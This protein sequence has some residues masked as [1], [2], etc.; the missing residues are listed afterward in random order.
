MRSNARPHRRRPGG[1]SDSAANDVSYTVD[2]LGEDLTMTDQNGSTHAY[3]ITLG[4]ETADAVTTL[5]S[6]VDGAVRRLTYSFNDAGLPYQQTSYSAASGGSVVNQEEDI[7]NGLWQLITQYQAASG[8]VSGGTPAV[9]YN[10][11]VMSDGQNNSKLESTVYPNG[12]ILDT[13]YSPNQEP[14]TGIAVSGTTATV[15]TAVAHGLSTGA[16]VTIA[17]AS[18]PALDGTFTITVTNSTHF[19]Y[20]FTGSASTDSSA[21]LTETPVSLDSTISRP[22]GLQDHAGSAAGTVLQGYTYLGLSTIVQEVDGNGTEMTYI[23]P[24][25]HAHAVG[26]ADDHRQR[27]RTLHRPGPLRPGRLPELV[28]HQHRR[29]DARAMKKE[30][31]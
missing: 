18:H 2:N 25:P 9:G 7:Y 19:T 22:D 20:T 13:D 29:A 4:R 10:Y 21:D 14:V 11:N 6:G 12:R 27:R 30:G 23:A 28:Q 24:T 31:P 3:A 5:G 26:P 16:T 15:A 8:S 1:A 17:G